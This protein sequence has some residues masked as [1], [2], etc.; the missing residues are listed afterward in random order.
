MNENIKWFQNKLCKQLIDFHNPGN[1]KIGE[2]FDARKMIATLVESGIDT[3]T[4]FSKD[5]YGHSYY[6]TKIG[7]KHPGLD[8]DFFGEL[9]KE[10]KKNGLHVMVY[11]AL[12]YE[13]IAGLKNNDWIVT[14]KDGSKFV[15]YPNSEVREY[16][17]AKPSDE[18]PLAGDFMFM[19]IKRMRN[20]GFHF[21]CVNSPYIQELFW[22]QLKEIATNYDID[23]FFLDMLFYPDDSCYCNYCRK[24][25]A[26]RGI[27]IEDKKAVHKFKEASMFRVARET[28][29]FIRSLNPKI[30]VGYDNTT[31]LGCYREKEY[32]DYWVVESQAWNFGFAHAPMHARYLRNTERPFE[33][34][35]TRF[36]HMWGDFGGYKHI[37]ELKFEAASTI[38]NGGVFQIGHQMPNNCEMEEDVYKNVKAC[39]DFV[40]ERGEYCVEATPLSSIAVYAK[41][42][43]PYSAIDK[44]EFFT[45]DRLRNF[46]GATKLLIEAHQQFDLVD[47]LM[48]ISKYRVLIIPEVK[49]LSALFIEKVRKFVKDGGV[50]ISSYLTSLNEDNFTLA[51]VLG[52]DYIGTSPYSVSYARITSEAIKEN[53]PKDFACYDTVVDVRP[54]ENTDVLGFF[55]NPLFE[56]SVSRFHS[57][58]QA[59][60]GLATKY[61][62]ATVH[63]YG[64]GKAVYM[65]I[66]VFSLFFKEDYYVYRT[67]V[68]NILHMVYTNNLVKEVKAPRSLEINLMEQKDKNRIILHL[69]NCQFKRQSLHI[70]RIEDVYPVRDLEVKLEMMK[71]V[72]SVNTVPDGEVSWKL[73]DGILELRISEVNIHNMVVINV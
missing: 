15:H 32:N 73:K 66:P 9:V 64:K 58:A 8:F 18:V 22:P 2:E 38:A 5:N 54:G 56:K 57:H 45:N 51:D 1:E 48:D 28:T 40:K 21:L 14:A 70:P 36:H 41:E 37:N 3:V 72:K 50:L 6:D 43:L 20:L 59:P 52:V 62:V 13:Y 55:V 44:I 11:H 67:F 26:L 33:F 12:N 27:D 30:I 34:M 31:Y 17:S 23:G 35:A 29:T 39:S 25:M 65:G 68:E 71:P 24:E 19:D 60:V 49:D 16:G 46:Q 69:I 7:F 47:D 53:I 61:P 10:A 63:K 42:P 4:L